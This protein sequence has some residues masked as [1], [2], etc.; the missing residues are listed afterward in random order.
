MRARRFWNNNQLGIILQANSGLPFNIRVDPR[1]ERRRRGQRS[2]ATASSAT[3]AAWA[4]CSTS[5]CATRASCRSAARSARELFFEAK[6]LFNTR[7]HRRREP[8]VATD[9]LGNPTTAHLC[10]AARTIR[11]RQ[12]RLRSALDPAGLQVHVLM[13]RFQA[14]RLRAA[15]FRC[16]SPGPRPR[17]L[18]LRPSPILI[19]DPDPDMR[20]T[21]A[22]VDRSRPR[23]SCLRPR[24]AQLRVAPVGERP[25]TSRSSWC[26]ASSP[27][28]ASSCRPTRIP[29]TR[30]TGCWRCLTTGRACAP[31]WRPRRAATAARTRSARRSSRRSACC[32][33][34][35]SLA[36]HRFDGAE[37]YFTRAVD[38]GF[39]FSVD[40]TFE[41]WGHDEITRR[42]RPAHPDDPPRRHRR[43]PLRRRRAAASIIRRR[44]S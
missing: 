34:R 31:R 32:G 27:T 3:P 6:N 40:E 12:E 41:K 30:T 13:P 4:A 39:S 36:L 8:R 5:T 9:A 2:P 11:C 20:R 18:N 26:C 24:R 22:S 15:G 25:T 16:S 42:L 10:S 33:P 14:F 43:L 17:S 35:S 7:E 38:F 29:T 21:S 23:S 19:P 1:P 28:P 37:Q 44:R